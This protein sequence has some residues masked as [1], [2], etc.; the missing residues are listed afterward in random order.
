MIVIKDESCFLIKGLR[1][2]T[3]VFLVI[4]W[5]DVGREKVSEIKENEDRK[6]VKGNIPIN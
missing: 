2:Q 6:E 4:N 5:W 1:S 3:W